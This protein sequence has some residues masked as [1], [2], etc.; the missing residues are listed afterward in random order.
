MKKKK[1][2]NLLNTKGLNLTWVDRVMLAGTIIILV[3][4]MVLFG[5]AMKAS[6]ENRMQMVEDA[7]DTL[8]MNQKLQME[9]FIEENMDTLK[10]LAAF[11][12]VYGMDT[13]EQRAFLKGRAAKAGFSH[14]FVVNTKGQGYYVDEDVT[15]NHSQEL[16]F[17]W[18]TENDTFVTP[19]YYTEDKAISTLSVPIYDSG[20]NKVGYLC[21]ALDLTQIR[22]LFSGNQFVLD[23]EWFLINTQGTYMAHSDMNKVTRQESLFNEKKSELSLVEKAIA[24]KAGQEGN[25][26]LRGAEWFCK[27]VYM[28][29]Y[30]WL[31]VVGCKESNILKD[32]NRLDV[33]HLL[34]TVGMILLFLLLVRLVYC[35]RKSDKKNYTDTLTGANSRASFER[36]LEKLE[37]NAEHRISIIYMD[38]NRFKE[39]NDTYGHEQGDRLLIAF[40]KSLMEVFK[41]QGFVARLGGDEFVCI[42]LDAAEEQIDR[43]IEQV[44]EKLRHKMKKEGLPTFV[45]TSYGVAHREKNYLGKLSE[46][47]TEADKRMYEYKEAMRRKSAPVPRETPVAETVEMLPMN[48]MPDASGEVMEE[49]N[50]EE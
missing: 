3:V 41:K 37:G 5:F 17:Q 9:S 1:G 8:A 15:R 7:M 4:G 34:H 11:P 19:P 38:L 32:L 14:I 24:E 33:L 25:I 30:Q 23:G 10:L 49:G 29:D 43:L 12:E 42:M 20:R 48:T 16:F 26:T 31:L 35:W 2:K 13:E 50:E 36:V 39:V 28:E 21:G 18:L 45:T 46:V 22:D 27:V 44:H 40:A 6:E 47:T